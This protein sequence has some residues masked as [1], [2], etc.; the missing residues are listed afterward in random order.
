M[1]ATVPATLD[2]GE[3]Y[4]EWFGKIYK[5]IAR[6]VNDLDVVED[7][8]S[9]VFVKAI[10]SDRRGQGAQTSF[11]GWLYRIAHN[12][13]IDHYRARD[14]RREISID[15]IPHHVDPNADPVKTIQLALDMAAVDRALN[16]LTQKQVEVL[17]LYYMEELSISEIALATGKKEEAIKGLL[18]RAWYSAHF[19]LTGNR[20]RTRLRATCKDEVQRVIDRF[21]PMP[22]SEIRIKLGQSDDSIRAALNSYPDMFIRVGTV[23][24]PKGLANVW[25]LVGIHD[26]EAA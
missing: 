20:E 1:N 5:Y 24:A 16:R 3:L 18:H 6:R 9:D 26:R 15:E 2:W 25:G 21:G 19:M 11:S 23:K 4:S 22:I 10:D 14:V 8:T 13:V 12:L 7:L 17:Q